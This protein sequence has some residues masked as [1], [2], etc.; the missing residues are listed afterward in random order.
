MEA[1]GNQENVFQTSRVICDCVNNLLTDLNSVS[2]QLNAAAGG[3]PQSE[4]VLQFLHH[5][6][7][8]FTDCYVIKLD[9]DAS[10]R[11]TVETKRHKLAKDFTFWVMSRL[12]RLIASPDCTKLH[13][14]AITVIL[15]ILQLARITDVSFYRELIKEVI[16]VYK[17]SLS[18]AEEYTSSNSGLVDSKKKVF[19]G[20]FQKSLCGSSSTSSMPPKLIEIFTYSHCQHLL[21]ATSEILLES[22]LHVQQYVNE[23]KMS[24]VILCFQTIQLCDE[25]LIKISL[26][27]M[28]SIMLAFPIIFTCFIEK[29]L[30]IFIG[31][32][33][34]VV[35]CPR[36]DLEFMET[37]KRSIDM[38]ILLKDDFFSTKLLKKLINLNMSREVHDEVEEFL[39]ESSKKMVLLSSTV[40]EE[41]YQSIILL[42]LKKVASQH[43]N[44]VKKKCLASLL[45]KAI[46]M[47]HSLSTSSEKLESHL[48]C[49]CLNLEDAEADHGQQH[50]EEVTFLLKVIA[51]VYSCEKIKDLLKRINFGKLVDKVFEIFHSLLNLKDIN[52]NILF[53]RTLSFLKLY[54]HLSISATFTEIDP[55]KLNRLFEV[56]TIPWLKT[57]DPPWF[58]YKPKYYTEN[59]LMQMHELLKLCFVNHNVTKRCLAILAT[60]TNKNQCNAPTWLIH[61]IRTALASPYVIL[62]LKVLNCLP[63]ILTSLTAAS[64][65]LVSEDLITLSRAAKPEVLAS[66]GLTINLLVCVV[67]ESVDTHYKDGSFIVECT[68][69]KTENCCIQLKSSPPLL[70]IFKP[71][72][73]LLKHSTCR[74]FKTSLMQTF[75]KLLKHISEQERIYMK[76]LWNIML[77]LLKDPDFQTRLIF[78]GWLGE[79]IKY[80]DDVSVHSLVVETISS[81]LS[82]ASEINDIKVLETVILTI[83]SVSKVAK[84][85]LLLVMV[86]SLFDCFVMQNHMVVAV[87]SDQLSELCKHLDKS[88]H[89]LFID[90]K[91]Y[92]C[93]IIV[94]KMQNL[95]ED[96]K[97]VQ[98]VTDT[99]FDIAKHFEFN[100]VKSFLMITSTEM[101]PKIVMKASPQSSALLRLFAKL[102]NQN[103]RE[104]MFNNF[105]YIFS[106]LIR[107]IVK[108]D[109]LEVCLRFLQEETDVELSSL[110]L[111]DKHR[112][113]NQL[114]L[115]ISVNREQ[116]VESFSI[117][118]SN[119]PSYKGPK[120]FKS[121]QD[122]ALFLHPK[123]LAVLA[124]FNS[125]LTNN[126]NYEKKIA[127]KSIICLF[128][129]MGAKYI[130]PV[131]L[132]V[133]AILKLALKFK[134]EFPEICCS[135]W[136]CFIK[137]IDIDCIGPLLSHLIAAILPLL[138]DCPNQ[139]ADIFN[140][141]IVENRSSL[142]VSFK[143]I[144]FVPQHPVLAN[145][146]E[147]LASHQLRVS[148]INDF[149]AKI[150]YTCLGID[151]ENEDVRN[152]ALMH[153]TTTLQTYSL[154]L[155]ELLANVEA[156]DPFVLN[157]I[158]TLLLASKQNNPQT[159]N[160]IGKCLGILG[161][162][163][164][165][166]IESLN[167]N[168]EEAVIYTSIS[169]ISFGC[170]LLKELCRSFLAAGSTRAQDCAAFAIQE[171][172]LYYECTDKPSDRPGY[173]LWERFSKSI[174][175]LLYPHLFSKYVNSTNYNL[176][177]H[178]TPLYQSTKGSSYVD[179]VCNWTNR[180]IYSL[181][182]TSCK[183]FMS[184]MS[185]IKHDL[186]VALFLLPHVVIQVVLL[187]NG[188]LVRDEFMAV[189]ASANSESSVS[190]F[191]KA[192]TNTVYSIMDYLNHWSAKH[193]SKDSS[194]NDI[195]E[196]KQFIYSIPKDILAKSS[197]YCNALSRSLMYYEQYI[198]V[199]KNSLENHLEFLQRLYFALDEPD[200]VTGVADT[201]KRNTT[202]QEQIVEH[203]SSGN[204]RDAVACYERAIQTEPNN[205]KHHKGLL[206]CLIGLGQLYN[207][208]M[209][210]NGLIEKRPEWKTD[211][212]P[213]Q[214]EISWRL[215]QWDSLEKT[216]PQENNKN[217]SLS[218][219]NLLLCLKNNVCD[220]FNVNIIAVRNEQMNCLRSASLESG[221]YQR[222]YKSIVRLHM[223]EDVESC[224][225]VCFKE[226]KLSGKDLLSLWDKRLL[227]TESSFQAREPILNMRRILL[228]LLPEF[229][230]KQTQQNA[231]WLMYSRIARK[232]GLFQTAYSSLLN[233]SDNNN[234]EILIEKAKWYSS[235][236][237]LHK[238]L[239]ILHKKSDDVLQS[240]SELK[241]KL[242]HAKIKLLKAK[243]MEDTESYEPNAVL[244][245]YKEAVNEF[246][247]WEKGHFYLAKY[248]E[249]LM[250]ACDDDLKDDRK[251]RK[252]DFLKF[253]IKHY[254]ESL[255]YGNK[256]I[257][258]S[259]PRLL[260][261]WLDFGVAAYQA[262]EG[263][264]VKSSEKAYFKDRMQKINDE[265]L[266]LSNQLPAYQFLTAFSQLVSRICHPNTSVWKLLEVIICKIFHAYKHQ[267]IWSMV[268][269]SKSS[270]STRGERC[271][272]VFHKVCQE[273]PEM[274]KFISHALDLT[275]NLLEICN[276]KCVKETKL[277]MSKDFSTLTKLTSDKSFSS[278]VVPL[279][280]TLTV[281]L[282]SSPDP[283]HQYNPFHESLPM[284]VG[285]DDHI[286][287]LSSLQ[288]PKKIKVKASDGNFY[289]LMCK[290]KDDLRK[291]GR[292]MEFN[293]LVNKMLLRD[294]LCRRRQLHI[295]TY[296]VIPL[297]EECGLLEWVPNTSGLRFILNNI[298]KEKGLTVKV[299]ELKQLYEPLTKS[300]CLKTKIDI[301]TNQILPRYPP[302]FHEWFISNF[303]NPTKWYAARLAYS[304]TSAVMSMVGYTLG[305]GDRH[306]ENILFDSISG[307]CVHVDFN[308]LFN[309][310]ESFDCPERVPFRLTHNMVKAM[311]PLGHE[312][313]FRKSCEV[314]MKVMRAQKDSL[315]SVL[316]TFLYDPLLE[317]KK[318]TRNKEVEVNNE[319]ALKILKKIEQRLSGYITSNM[320]HLPLSIE[321][322]VHHLI[323]ESTSIE[324]L[325]QM[326]IGWAAYM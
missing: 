296:A 322:Q 149:K 246:S 207:G 55:N 218:L 124:F 69:C 227:N 232:A 15:S 224:A 82:Q 62:Q 245:Q 255:H 32:V 198:E 307:D 251:M 313:V 177:K 199:A 280:S 269:V 270:L 212:I 46:L 143:D 121:D 21:T 133:M 61:V 248:Y 292:L 239:L 223:L 250:N 200:G 308:C 44:K 301:F 100:D 221:G 172:L 201:R 75:L 229:D 56:C 66:I 26:S 94:R 189:L 157:L 155:N 112:I 219:S 168:S 23:S 281:K 291:D 86:V 40:A 170:D 226:K 264:S 299:H 17:D 210:V 241:K 305:L 295:R 145:C 72:F 19:S 123:L 187:K 160:Y 105:T 257:Y 130:T 114:L 101:L 127:L 68:L 319:M 135:A 326:Y 202:L 108:H 300:T 3:I 84:G 197:F 178:P 195:Q 164:P 265:I 290:P 316:N 87:A 214:A 277:S 184:C 279:Q 274:T 175:E 52:K 323:K 60:V 132:K 28:N 186:K 236:N 18:V 53:I 109:E 242:L 152:F 311:G 293:S 169:D 131:R 204:L 203:E 153:L 237:D 271:K 29:Y 315:L 285:F 115:Y 20:R 220:Q 76:N 8:A 238:A 284:I 70:P 24:L 325:S 243:W 27:L 185:I 81:T 34:F 192:C 16:G 106:Y 303:T 154:F 252:N 249:K 39:L 167:E 182:K 67:A 259:M 158:N 208:L 48:L 159:F 9:L 139:V 117:L 213:Y 30:C 77:E 234:I 211:L 111:S 119:D 262:I 247:S 183:V 99:I 215:G 306:G 258:Q 222:A 287:V 190:E 11:N 312:G 317:W 162:I 79:Y 63:R 179:W 216:L 273:N 181:G 171:T 5:C 95:L 176:S 25:S 92:F 47:T 261:L 289:T 148:N 116:V 205:V 31:V 144:Y 98:C 324:N 209:D 38:I 50:L 96:K 22:M 51:K 188:G 173:R 2:S 78:S 129:I 256:Y 174:Q 36:I 6:T 113:Y 206:K 260:T 83:G 65:T 278:I 90:H 309:K 42:C 43:L 163:D 272:H 283:K 230:Q 318:E 297:N 118:A 35:S 180:L 161:A 49:L 228:Q 165:G 314:T 194:Q 294:P 244:L 254:G 231:G 193:I 33:E 74:A 120:D 37:L 268:A 125:V 235:Q 85:E 71:F 13:K 59:E 7:D 233:V 110:L 122:L 4:T 126:P 166:R 45:Q 298:Y 97:D 320:I 191:I 64:E 104:M 141:L 151:N 302:V 286:D 128:N 89:H 14:K 266:N 140:F 1:T 156:I 102:T 196:I 107:S 73:K 12:F 57:I 275:D 267:A 217:W 225:T 282:P 253:V 138:D 263:A 58:D 288:K 310:G 54:S 147:I 134:T 240:Q 137:N 93:D 80:T 150:K 136:S 142:S 276:R 304:R 10:G 146:G 91:S 41:E 103:R 88:L 321:G